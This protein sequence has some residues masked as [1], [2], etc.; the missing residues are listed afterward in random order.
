MT[1]QEW[2]EAGPW[3]HVI[4]FSNELLDAFP[5]HKLQIIQGVPYEIFVGWDMEKECF[6]EKRLPIKQE[7]LMSFMNGLGAELQ[8]GQQ[9]EVNLEAAAWIRR[10]G[11]SIGA[12]QLITIDYGDLAEE[13]YAAHRMKGTLMCYRKHAAED[14]PYAEPGNQDI[15]AHINF[16]QLIHEGKA[17]GLQEVQFITQKQFLVDN[18]LLQKL[19]DT[20]STDPFSPAAKRNRAVRQLLLSDQMSELFK[21]LIQ[22]KGELP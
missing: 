7:H 2:L 13:L 6:Y 14:N 4:V 8:E 16:S 21:V 10:I 19:Q 20:A 5:V 3:E 9:L 22:K 18:G 11:N 1:E 12:G 15:T 17:V